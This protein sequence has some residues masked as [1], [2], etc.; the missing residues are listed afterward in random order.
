MDILRRT[1]LK[2]ASASGVLAAAL[3]AGLLKP[4]QALAL[5]WNK[6]AFEAK[7][8]PAAMK[9]VGAASAAESKDLK[10]TA[11]DIAEN[12][13]VVPVDV[14]SG[15]ANTIS[16]AVF[17]DKNPYP[18][19]A[20]FNFSNGAMADVAVRLKMGQTSI[21]RAVAKTSDGKFYTAS[22]E[23]KVTAGGCGG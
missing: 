19:A 1:V 23:V 21:V 10:L 6:A 20:A 11:P 2:G 14:S 18:L 7:D 13:A 22:K 5:D 16:I 9:A 15:I 12:G 3:G 8:T 17:V 4:T